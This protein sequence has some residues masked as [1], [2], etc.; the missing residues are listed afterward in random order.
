MIKLVGI[1]FTH[2][3]LLFAFA[4]KN[5]NVENDHKKSLIGSWK[6]M[7]GKWH[8]GMM[9]TKDSIF[10]IDQYNKVWKPI[11]NRNLGVPYQLT[12]EDSLIFGSFSDETRDGYGLTKGLAGRWK[13]IKLSADSISVMGSS[14]LLHFKRIERHKKGYS[15]K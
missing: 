15:K 6:L 12:E 8:P 11:G 3:F 7:D 14:G 13:V 9:L 4:C 5:S 2:I 10:A 1:I